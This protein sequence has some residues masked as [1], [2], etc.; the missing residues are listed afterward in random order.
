MAKKKNQVPV[1]GNLTEPLSAEEIQAREAEAAKDEATVEEPKERPRL[2]RKAARNLS[3]IADDAEYEARSA[4]RD[5]LFAMQEIAAAHSKIAL[6]N[7]FTGQSSNLTL[8]ANAIKQLANRAGKFNVDYLKP[9]ARK[10]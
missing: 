5:Q 8:I 4:E 3:D 1:G 2:L 7:G 9:K 6:D 10:A